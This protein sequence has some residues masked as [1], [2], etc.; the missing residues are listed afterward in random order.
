V[1]LFRPF[2][3][4]YMIL[5]ANGRGAYHPMDVENMDQAQAGEC[6]RKIL[7]AAK[8][9]GWQVRSSSYNC[10]ALS[11]CLYLLQ[12]RFVCCL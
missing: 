8:V 10:F 1:C 4:R 9:D 7:T 5:V 2:V 12:N 3:Q 6:V 11:M